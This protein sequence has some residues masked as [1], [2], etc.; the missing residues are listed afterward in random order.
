M[1]EPFIG[2]IRLMAFT[3]APLGWLACDGQLLSINQNTALFSLLGT[4]FGGNGVTNFAIPDLRGRAALGAQGQGVGLSSY[5]VGQDAGTETVTLLPSN[6]PVHTH[7]MP[8][9]TAVATTGNP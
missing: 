7:S 8:A 9:S 6:M 4:Q 5:F 2:E 1:A 3:F